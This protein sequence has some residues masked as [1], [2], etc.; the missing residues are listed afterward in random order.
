[1]A[2]I[3]T[4]SQLQEALDAEM[5]WR[6]KEISDFKL[7][8]KGQAASSKTFIRAGVALIYAHW[9][10]FIKASSEIYLNFVDNQGHIYRD[11]KTCFAVFGLKGRLGLLSSGRKA[12]SNI[13]ALDF[14]LAEMDKP[15]KMSMSSAIDTESNLSSKVFVNIAESLD[16]STEPYATKFKLIDES[17]V[18]R[19]NKVA[20]G[21]YLDLPQ[22][23]FIV[24][25]DEVLQMMR[26]YKTDIENAATLESYKRLGVGDV[27][28]AVGTE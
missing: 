1:M 17:L 26:S 21:E 9:E 16:I 18:S 4:L 3:R 13:E 10:G 14:V 8:T 5:S 24:L 22:A 6:I 19:R 23:D 11:L 12:R 7:A 25:A 27:R 15:A 20:H 2:K 28:N